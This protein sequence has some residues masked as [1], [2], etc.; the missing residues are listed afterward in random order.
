MLLLASSLVGPFHFSWRCVRFEDLGIEVR[1]VGRL[2]SGQLAAN[3]RFRKSSRFP[4]PIEVFK[5]LA[6]KALPRQI[7]EYQVAF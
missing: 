3:L 6:R 2:A 4:S 5:A 1:Q 7:P